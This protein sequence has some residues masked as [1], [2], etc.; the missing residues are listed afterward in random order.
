[1][2]LRELKTNGI[3]KRVLLKNSRRGGRRKREVNEQGGAEE[4]EGARTEARSRASTRRTST[5]GP[6]LWE[7]VGFD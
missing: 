2:T 4:K 3:E 1:M 6:G 7:E 5:R